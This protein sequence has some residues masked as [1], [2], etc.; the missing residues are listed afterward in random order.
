[1]ILFGQYKDIKR[2]RRYAPHPRNTREWRQGTVCKIAQRPSQR[3]W[4][5]KTNTAT[6][7]VEMVKIQKKKKTNVKN[8]RT[9]K[10]ALNAALGAAKGCGCL[11]SK[12]PPVLSRQP[13]QDACYITI[14]KCSSKT[15]WQM[16]LKRPSVQW[17]QKTD[18]VAAC[19]VIRQ[20]TALHLPA[21]WNVM[22]IDE[23][24]LTTSWQSVIIDWL[25][26]GAF[27][28]SLLNCT[29]LYPMLHYLIVFDNASFK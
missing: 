21:P 28:A 27:T 1:M 29:R 6:R 3:S 26:W 8:N 5:H 12:T 9:G 4:Q 18:G 11:L 24:R 10:E 25:L 13:Y 16:L 23:R 7:D 15:K 14:V 19:M 2:A 17:C 20:L 22:Q